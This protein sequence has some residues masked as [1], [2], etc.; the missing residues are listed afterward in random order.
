MGD[1]L[2]ALTAFFR[3]PLEIKR[4]MYI[5]NIIESVNSKFREAT[6]GRRVISHRR[7]FVKM[8]IYGSYGAGT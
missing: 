3:Y 6:A 1:K 8:L 2:G 7:I 4:V 5:T